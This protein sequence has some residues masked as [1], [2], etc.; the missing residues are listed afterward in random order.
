LSNALAGNILA[1]SSGGYKLFLVGI[2]SADFR[3]IRQ[4]QFGTGEIK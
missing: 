1:I 3:V 2:V 4:A